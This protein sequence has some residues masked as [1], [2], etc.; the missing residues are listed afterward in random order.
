MKRTTVVWTLVG[1]VLVSG[2]ARAQSL[3]DV[4][5][6]EEE[7][8]KAVKA[9]SKLYTNDDLRRYPTTTPPDADKPATPAPPATGEPAAGP[10]AS[11]ASG[12]AVGAAP[13]VD[14]GEDYWRGLITEARARLE[15]SKGYF[16]ALE[17]RVADLTTQFYARDDSEQRAA[18][19]SQRAKILA[20]MDHLKQDM[21]DQEKAVAKIEEDARHA[22][23]PPGW[24]R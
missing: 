8:R 3:A 21:A 23:V 16:D 20:D 18:I 2:V 15:R 11:G 4:A 7:R 24:I 9:P 22:N 1:A 17:A 10:P 5:R 12:A 6:K 14:R 19:W 13:S